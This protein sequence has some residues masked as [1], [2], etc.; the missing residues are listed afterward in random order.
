MD[1]L[2]GNFSYANIGITALDLAT[3]AFEGTILI[4][5]GPGNPPSGLWAL[6]FGTGMG[7]GGDPLLYGRHQQRE[8]RAVRCHISR[9]GASHLGH[10]AAWPCRLGPCFQAVTKQGVVRLK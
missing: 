3:G 2:V 8:G 6:S 1:L 5:V 9:P 7:I 4:N 10:D